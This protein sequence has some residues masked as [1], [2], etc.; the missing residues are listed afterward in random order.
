MLIPEL[1]DALNEQLNR[2]FYSAYLYLAMSAFFEE[3]SLP[4]CAHWMRLQAKEELEHGMK[5]YAYIFSR[6]GVVSLKAIDTAP[7][8]WDSALSAFESAYKHEKEVSKDINKIADLSLAKKDHATSQ[9]LLWFVAEQVEEEATS[10]ALIDRFKR[11]GNEAAGM[12]FVDNDL[13]SRA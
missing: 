4:G 1:E 13:A 12:V 3:E 11:I 6:G 7:S 10:K 2:E 9:F 5:F 8:G